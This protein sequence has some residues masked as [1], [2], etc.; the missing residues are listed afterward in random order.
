V[1]L[2]DIKAKLEGLAE[3]ITESHAGFILVEVSPECLKEA[4]NILV[5]TGFDHVSCVEGI[6]KPGDGVIEVT[7]YAESYDEDKRGVIIGLRVKVPRDNP[8][9]P[10]LIDVWPSAFYPERETWDLVGVRFEG[11]PELKRLLMP[12]DWE[13]PPPLRKD[14]KV[15]EEGIVVG[16]GR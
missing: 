12:P 1:S 3:N 5:S 7:Y 15:K 8:T 13:G 2:N 11:H 9:V 4:A 14:F 6:D 10:S 16:G